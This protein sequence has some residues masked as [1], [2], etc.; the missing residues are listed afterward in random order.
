MAN[1]ITSVDVQETEKF[2]LMVKPML[3]DPKISALPFDI[4]V[5]PFKKHEIYFKGNIG[6]IASEKVGC[7]WSYGGSAS[8]TKKTLTPVEIQAAVEQC[9]DELINTI[10]A[11]ALGTGWQRGELTPEVVD[12]LL[13]QQQYEFNRDLLSMLFLGDTSISDTYYSVLDGFYKKL[14]AGIGGGALDGGA[15]TATDVNTTN[16]FDTLNDIYN[17]QARELKGVDK[18]RKVWIWTQAVYDAYIAYLTAKTQTSAGIIQTEYITNGIQPIAFNGIKIFVPQIVDERLETD[19]L[20]GSPAA[21][22][23]PYRVVLT[24][25]ENHKVLMDAD[26]FMKQNVW[27]SNDDDMY[28]VAGSATIAYAYGFDELNVIAG[29]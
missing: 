16:F 8:V 13:T 24:L 22:T 23:D 12:Y 18:S 10:F 27:Y 2:S 25:G 28:R 29:F 5:G 6:K 9:Y 1:V 11:G 20:T 15:I 7:G 4:L 3:D 17:L 14:A 21:P 19:F 26:G